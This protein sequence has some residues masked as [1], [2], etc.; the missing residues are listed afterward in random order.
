MAALQRATLGVINAA[1]LGVGCACLAAAV[2]ALAGRLI[3]A[4]DVLSHFAPLWFLGG[5]ASLLCGAVLA[6][7]SA[8]RRSIAV[9]ALASVAAAL[10]MAPEILRPRSAP[11]AA[12]ATDRIRLIQFN[13]WELNREP[14]AAAEWI[15]AQKPDI[16]VIEELTP[17]L[18]AALVRCGFIYQRGMTLEMAIFSRIPPGP[19]PFIVPLADW[20][21]L[22]EFARESFLAPGGRGV[23][24][25][26]AVHFRWPTEPEAWWR[27]LRMTEFLNLYDPDRLI[28][29]GDLNL[30]PWSSTLRRFDRGVGVERRDRGMPTW[31]ARVAVDGLQFETPAYLPIDH[32]YAGA[33]WRTI[34]VRRGP[35]MGS[36]HYP[37]IV[38]L[39]LAPRAA[40]SRLPASP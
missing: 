27:A 23:F 22:P 38:D 12:D 5:L 40:G 37:L 4:F 20:P 7:G 17:T 28:V 34:M 29:A 25:V 24:H 8:R 13:A 33:D 18:H 6:R 31:P 19:E 14:V 39:A 15:A 1:G 9:G 21:I 16:V 10:L 35:S 30:T 32:V 26:V 3:L 2:L 36:D 11:A